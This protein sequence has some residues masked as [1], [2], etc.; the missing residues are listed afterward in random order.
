[1]LLISTAL[2][3]AAHQ[4]GSL[5]LHYLAHLSRLVQMWLVVEDT[6]SLK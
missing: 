4:H 6:N 5:V 1:M 3:Y 2:I